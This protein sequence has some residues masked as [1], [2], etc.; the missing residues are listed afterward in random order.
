M[1]LVSF[2]AKNAFRNT[3][4][5]AL[6]AVSLAVSLALIVV[7]QT[8]LLEITKPSGLDESIPRVIVRHRT[9]LTMSL[10]RPYEKK[11]RRLDGIVDVTPMQWFGGIWKDEDF[12]NFFPQ[13]G[14]D[15]DHFFNVYID[16]HPLEPEMLTALKNTRNGCLVGTKLAERH[17]FKVGDTIAIKGNIYPADLEL[18]VVGL[19]TGPQPDWCIFQ[20]KYLDELLG[21]TTPAGS[22][23]MLAES[24]ARV[25]T[26]IPEVE[27]MFRNSDAEVKAETEKAFQLSFVEMLGNVK[28]FIN[29]L[30]SVVI[31]AVLMIAASTM[32]LAIRER[33]RE[34]AT[35]KAIGFTRT[36]VLVLVVGEGMVV[37]CLG[38]GLGLAIA[39]LFLPSP[40]WFLAGAAGILVSVVL[41]APLL[42][43]AI[44]LPET[45]ASGI[46]RR[47]LVRFREFLNEIGPRLSI[48]TGLLVMLVLLF[49]LPSLDWFA[50]SGGMIQSMNVRNETLVLGTVVTVVVGFLSSLWPAWQ[51]SRMSVLD[52]LRTLE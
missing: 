9:S 26:L 45:A 34:I 13:F 12:K 32:A 48:Y 14:V 10:P 49:V 31:F 4:R 6:T 30:V 18:K 47:L 20:L 29:S 7:L 44:L 2:M 46:K 22:F 42:L 16:Y 23:F 39:W 19:F 43:M 8:I 25:E 3:R 51:A 36:Q 28:V 37:S 24:P 50:F 40:K 15:P 1:T 41:G 38:G 17:G 52:G 33:T 5:T 11:L 35:L 27:A 21:E